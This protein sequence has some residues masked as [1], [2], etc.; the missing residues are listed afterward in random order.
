MTLTSVMYKGNLYDDVEVLNNSTYAIPGVAGLIS[1]TDPNLGDVAEFRK[2]SASEELEVLESESVDSPE[3]FESSSSEVVDL[4]DPLQFPPNNPP[5]K[6]KSTWQKWQ[7]P[8][9]ALGL[10]VVISQL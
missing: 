1:F 5:P 9:L 3:Q 6:P 4:T 7:L 10:V 2:A 8:I